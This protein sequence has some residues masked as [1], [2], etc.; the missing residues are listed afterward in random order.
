MSEQHKLKYLVVGGT[1]GIGKAITKALEA[2][3]ASV[4]AASR[5]T[6]LNITDSSSITHYL[7]AFGPFDHLVITAGSSAPSGFVSE[8]ALSRAKSAFDT[9]FWGSIAIARESTKYLR[10]GGSITFTSGFLSRRTVAGTY[11][12]TAMNAAIEGAAK[13]LAKELSPIRVNTVSPG[14]TNTEAYAEMDSDARQTMFSNA[15]QTLPAGKVGSPEELAQGYL[16]AMDNA[17]M[18]GTVIDLDGGAL[19]N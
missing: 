19:I 10:P 15:A 13:V 14:L 1:S 7:E 2:R 3:G 12:K 11:V 16:F 18:T 8:V 6:G 17:F 9:K 5:A 4:T